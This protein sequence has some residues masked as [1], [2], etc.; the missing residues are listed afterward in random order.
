MSAERSFDPILFEVIRN[1]LLEAT[2][3]MS[4]ALQRTAFSTNIKTRLDYSCAYVDAA[5]RMVAQSFG[6][7]AHLV[8]AGTLV[9]RA[10]A[11]FGAE[12]IHPGDQLVVNDPHRQASHLNDFFFIAPF[13]YESRLLGYVTN[14]CHHVDVGGGAPA[15]IGAFR[16]TYQEGLILPV[17]KL[18]RGGDIDAGLW[19]VILANVR[20]K[21]EVAGDMRA[22]IAA[23]DM[24]L[25][26]LSS[27][28]ERYGRETIEFYIDRLLDYTEKR[29]RAEIEQLPRGIVSAE[30]WLDDDGI[31]DEPVHL[32]ARVTLDGQR[33]TFDFT[34]S[35]AQRWAPMNCN[36]TQTFTACVYVLKCLV[37][38]DIPVNEG[39]YAPIEVIAPKG[40]VLNARHP[41][42]IVGGW[43]VSMRVCEVLFKAFSEILPERVPAGTKGM[44][45]HVGFGGERPHTGEYYTFLET[46][47]GGYGGR[48]NSDGPDAVQTHFQ[49]TQNAPVEETEA[50]YPVRITRLALIPDS[51]GPGKYRGGLGLCREYSF[52]DHEPVFTMLADRAKFA[53]EGLF[54][55]CDGRHA[56]YER[57]R[58]DK[59]E[60]IP[61]KGTT[62]VALGERIRVETAGGGGYG[63]AWER[64]PELV[65][66]DVIEEKVSAERAR[67][68]YGVELDTTSWRVDAPATQRLRVALKARGQDSS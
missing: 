63:L 40:T 51:E 38:S 39:F 62:D 64:D 10:V 23:N 27:L 65:L 52:T 68:V 48:F 46:L 47:A 3:E 32:C 22:Q 16:E 14:I 1:A 36:F 11:E 2:E 7:P 43:E 35:D 54:G 55:G 37:D 20:A 66:R 59:R 57:V 29:T 25:Q 13:Y 26:R 42:A 5:G 28:F 4:V 61:S 24:G 30:G 8:T 6:Q 49:N 34:G 21:K 33:V 15:S 41:G 50:N 17:V 12:N 56:H 18:V 31:T 19:K 45:C 53:P 58:D 67:E 60:T 44:I 9:P